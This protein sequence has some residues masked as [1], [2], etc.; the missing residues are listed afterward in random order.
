MRK[1]MRTMRT[2][3]TMKKKMRRMRMRMN[4]KMR[5]GKGK[6]KGKGKGKGTIPKRMKTA[7]QNLRG[8]DGGK[9]NRRVKSR[10]SRKTK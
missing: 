3:R 9:V 7:Y 5:K 4:L 6:E 10:K 2:M 8:K 1:K